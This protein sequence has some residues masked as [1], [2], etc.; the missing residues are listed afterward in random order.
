MDRKQGE[1]ELKPYL[2][3]KEAVLAEAG[4]GMEGLTD[5]EAAAR[6]NRDGPNKLR[7]GKKDSL[8]KKFIGELKDPM[9]IVLIIAAIVSAVTATDNVSHLTHII[10]GICGAVIGVGLRKRE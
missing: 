3:D 5:E 1:K 2:E 9:T 4:S 6:L 8:L 7:E 10:G